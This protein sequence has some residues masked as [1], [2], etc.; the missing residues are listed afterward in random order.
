M[1][2]EEKLKMTAKKLGKKR[3]R[4]L[5]FEIPRGKLTAQQAIMLTGVEEELPSASDVSKGNDIELQEIRENAARSTENLIARKRCP[6][7]N[8]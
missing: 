4:G 3:L 7:A 1:T 8:F 2:G 5:G 6:R